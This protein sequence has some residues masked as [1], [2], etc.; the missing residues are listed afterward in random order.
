MNPFDH[1]RAVQAVVVPNSTVV[2]GQ[3]PQVLVREIDVGQHSATQL[4]GH[5]A[6]VNTCE[7]GGVHRLVLQTFGKTVQSQNR[8][9]HGVRPAAGG[10]EH[11]PPVSVA[12]PL[13]TMRSCEKAALGTCAQTAGDNRPLRRHGGRPRAS[14]RRSLDTSRVSLRPRPSP[15]RVGL[16]GGISCVPCSHHRKIA[17]GAVDGLAG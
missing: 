6:E 7:L 2:V 12:L 5:A 3:P 16:G 1:Q 15:A 9:R 13:Q 17:W 10:H 14:L 8:L 11:E 4:S